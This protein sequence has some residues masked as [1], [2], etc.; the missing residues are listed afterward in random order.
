MR[1]A[2]LFVSAAVLAVALIAGVWFYRSPLACFAWLSRVALERAGMAQA[3]LAG[4]RGPLAVFAGGQGPT[5]LLIHGAND[6]A[7]AWA[8]VAAPLLR[9]HRVV[10]LDL[11]GHGDSAPADGPLGIGDLLAGLDVVLAAERSP[12]TLVGNSLG[13][14]L[15]LHLALRHPEQ[16]ARVVLVNGAAHQARSDVPLLPRTRT[17]ARRALEALTG[18]NARMP[19]GF[20]LDDLVRRSAGSPMARLF[21]SDL[22]AWTLDERLADVSVPVTLVWGDAD[23]LMPLAYAQAA[24]AKLGSAARLVTLPGCGHIPMRE[25]PERLAPA[26]LAAVEGR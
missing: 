15:A 5:V 10:A 20:V 17:E 13:G 18:P 14:F 16:V 8:G 12:V 25:C 26:L 24:Q 4:P 1:R 3:A 9:G 2:L 19:P 21:R 7:G 6:Q 22:P 23:E 11:P